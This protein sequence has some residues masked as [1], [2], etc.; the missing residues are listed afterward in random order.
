MT[1]WAVATT[2]FG[3]FGCQSGSKRGLGPEHRLAEVK[4]DAAPGPRATLS[5]VGSDSEVDVVASRSGDTLVLS[6]QV[7]DVEIEREVYSLA[8]G[9]FALVEAMGMTYEPPIPLLTE[10]SRIGDERDWKGKL[11]WAGE[12]SV[13]GTATIALSQGRLEVPDEPAI[14]VT[15]DL[16]VES[17]ARSPAKRAMKFWF[18]PGQGLLKRD[19]ASG[20]KRTLLVEFPDDESGG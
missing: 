2:L 16:G 19:F 15:V 13:S 17:G 4:P 7:F 9:G 20:T 11:R 12:R 18:V 1:V 8:G 3:V 10:V 6:L 14:L 5:M